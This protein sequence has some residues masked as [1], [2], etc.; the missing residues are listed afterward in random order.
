MKNFRKI[1]I[2]LS[3]SII[4]PLNYASA[5][6]NKIIDILSVNW[7]NSTGQV[8]T[9]DIV[10][11][12]SEEVIPFWLA[13]GKQNF[14]LGGVEK[15]VL[16]LSAPIS[17]DTVKAG[18]TM[19]SIAKKYY[20]SKNE[21]Q[22]G[23]YLIINSPD[24]KGCDWSGLGLQGF[25]TSQSGVLILNANSIPEV[26][27]HELGH[28]LGLG[29]D[30][31]MS[32]P[33]YSNYNWDNCSEEPYAGGLDV[34]GSIPL[35]TPLSVYHQWRLGI[36]PTTDILSVKNS[37][38]D[39]ELYSPK[40]TSGLRALYIHDKGAVYLIEYL[41]PDLTKFAGLVVL[42]LDSQNDY[43]SGLSNSPFY[44]G[45]SLNEEWVINTGNYNY[46]SEPT[47]S[48]TTNNFIT[49]DGNVTVSAEPNG[50]YA[51]ILIQVKDPSK[52]YPMFPKSLAEQI[53]KPLK[54]QLKQ[55]KT[56]L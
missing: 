21:E 17:C 4:L 12:L 39:F 13:Y 3:I 24:I 44:N 48:Y 15:N 1:I 8:D 31:L 19:T 55:K 28:N 43:N 29:H 38:N 20:S 16:N 40:L 11:A 7:A 37:S 23:H 22:I 42:R 45:N 47:G 6:D 52:L 30:N 36:L 53:T 33:D 26:I 32:C 5:S 49:Y 54:N 18:S 56:L 34:M 51:Q 14:V 10:S 27:E 2:L 50:N 46:S 35:D 25:V 9:K 41:S